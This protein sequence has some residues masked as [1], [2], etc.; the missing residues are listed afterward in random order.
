MISC[1]LES[2]I[3]EMHPSTSSRN[4]FALND[5]PNRDL[6]WVD[7]IEIAAAEVNPLMTGL[8]IKLTIKPETNENYHY[9]VLHKQT[10]ILFTKLKK[11][12]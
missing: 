3:L 9:K 11:T 7:V 4:P 10:I 1:K 8:D 6:T 5:N 2:E 12:H